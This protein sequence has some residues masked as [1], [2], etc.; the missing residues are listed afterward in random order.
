MTAYICMIHI[1][2][3]LRTEKI[4]SNT[5]CFFLRLKIQFLLGNNIHLNIKV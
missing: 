2:Q 3:Y 4:A 5:Y 1:L